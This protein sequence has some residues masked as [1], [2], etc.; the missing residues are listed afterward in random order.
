MCT[1]YLLQKEELNSYHFSSKYGLNLKT[2][3]QRIQYGK[4]KNSDF[5]VEKPGKHYLNQ[6]IK[7]NFTSDKSC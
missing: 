6:I 1:Y 7:V 5:I 2:H 4:G 3:I